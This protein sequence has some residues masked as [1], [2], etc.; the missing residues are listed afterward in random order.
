[1]KRM[2]IFLTAVLF[3]QFSNGQGFS[4]AEYYFDTDPGINNGIAVPLS[5]TSDTINFNTNISTSSLLPG[6]HFLALRVK[7]NSGTWGLFETRG[8]YISNSTADAAN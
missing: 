2:L 1:M 4:K 7:H 5:G 6:F 3:A 8:F